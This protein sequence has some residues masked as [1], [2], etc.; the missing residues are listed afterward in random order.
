MKTFNCFHV[1][2]AKFLRAA[3]FIELLRC[4][5]AASVDVLFYIIFSKRRCWILIHSIIVSLPKP[6]ITPILL[7]FYLTLVVIRCT[8]C[9]H[10]LLLV[11]VHCHSLSFVVTRCRSL[12]FVVPLVVNL[13]ITLCHSMS[14]VVPLVVSLVVRLVCLF[15]NDP[16]RLLFKRLN[17]FAVVFVV[18]YQLQ[19]FSK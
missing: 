18:N 5:G 15:I 9:S 4:S 1:N 17:L 6:K 16:Y 10:S 2:S 11:A 13:C 19:L 7:S 8:T 14:F 3:F 12:S